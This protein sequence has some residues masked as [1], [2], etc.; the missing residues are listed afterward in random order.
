VRTAKAE[1]QRLKP[2]GFGAI[3]VV[4]KATT[5]KDKVELAAAR[6]FMAEGTTYRYESERSRAN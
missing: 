3:H 1:L 6:M 2:L 4:A 5:H